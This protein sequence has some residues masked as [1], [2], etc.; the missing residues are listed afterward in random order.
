MAGGALSIIS[1]LDV[2]DVSLARDLFP[3][4]LGELPTEDFNLSSGKGLLSSGVSYLKHNVK[5]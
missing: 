2:V 3:E 5:D 1:A 4:E